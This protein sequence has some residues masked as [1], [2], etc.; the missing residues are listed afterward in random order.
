MKRTAF[1]I[2][3]ILVLTAFTAHAQSPAS[4]PAEGD[5]LH[6]FTVVEISRAESLG[7]DMLKLE[8]DRTG[9]RV[10]FVK[11]DDTNLGFSICFHT[12]PADDTGMLHILEHAVCAA[13]DRYPGRDVFFDAIGQAYLTGLN[14][15]TSLSSTN[16]YATSMDENQLEVLADFYLDCAFHSALLT[17]PNYFRREG[18]RYEMETLDD[19]LTVNGIVYNE[20]Q[21]VEGDI[22][23][24]AMNN[25][26][27]ALFPDT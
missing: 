2:L 6:G 15:W 20:M 24:S 10:I 7:A 22:V 25:A 8:H 17:E 9:A 23:S 27:N 18:W 13:S 12:E 26:S 1:L 4:L 14:A 19:E 21:G 3:L 11:N 16:Y 5:T